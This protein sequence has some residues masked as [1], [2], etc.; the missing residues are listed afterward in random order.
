MVV[1][2]GMGELWLRNCIPHRIDGFRACSIVLIEYHKTI[3]IQSHARVVAIEIIGVRPS[4]GGHQQMRPAN[5]GPLLKLHANLPIVSRPLFDR[6]LKLEP[7][8]FTSEDL[9]DFGGDLWIFPCEQ[10]WIAIDNGN[11]G[12]ESPEHLAKLAADVSTSQDQEVS[13][14]RAKLHQSGVVQPPDA[15]QS[16]Q[17]WND[18]A[19]THIDDHCFCRVALARDIHFPLADK[20]RVPLKNGE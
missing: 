19:G 14:Q 10:M 13:R 6:R 1:P 11:V 5:F 7:N 17:G 8:P 20:A 9:L 12:T 2:G 15:L 18:W 4:P 3:F 16:G